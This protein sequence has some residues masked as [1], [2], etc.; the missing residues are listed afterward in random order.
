MNTSDPT[1]RHTLWLC[2]L[3]APPAGRFVNLTF[4]Y[5]PVM[6]TLLDG[7]EDIAQQSAS[8][9][10]V[11]QKYLAGG[12]D[13]LS[14]DFARTL[15]VL[16]W[17]GV[18]GAWLVPWQQL[19][20]H[21]VRTVYYATENLQQTE[22]S[23]WPR[24]IGHDALAWKDEIWTHSRANVDVLR[25]LVQQRRHEHKPSPES[26]HVRYL[27]PG[28]VRRLHE[29]SGSEGGLLRQN[30]SE[31][32][33]LGGGP[34]APG[35]RGKMRAACA[36]WLQ[37]R[38]SDLG[39]FLKSVDSVWDDNAFGELQ[40]S[41]GLYLS[42]H[43]SCN[44]SG[45]NGQ[46]PLEAVRMSQLLSG[47]GTRAVLSERSAAVDEAEFAGLVEFGAIDALPVIAKRLVEQPFLQ[48][49]REFARRFAPRQLLQRA[50][51]TSLDMLLAGRRDAPALERT[52]AV[53]TGLTA[54][55]RTS[56]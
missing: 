53:S 50:G 54:V 11:R 8:K 48:P 33:F 13:A 32:V 12:R 47:R 56:R 4:M 10:R 55:P 6:E 9:W 18:A 35:L 34:T 37:P 38:L 28:F 31:I 27:P 1:R 7:A 42:L 49:T 40:R 14:F 3:V 29:A 52:A 21:G 39:L 44:E 19:W 22:G 45:S 2:Q 23:Q 16:C 36:A 24:G 46:A 26:P 5:L 25:Q 43:K 15:D 30:L 20:E 51:V 17:I 41:N